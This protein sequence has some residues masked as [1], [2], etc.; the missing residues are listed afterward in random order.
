MPSN[1]NLCVGSF[2]RPR[3]APWPH[4]IYGLQ[5]A[6]SDGV[7]K[8][9]GDRVEGDYAGEVF[10][11]GLLETKARVEEIFP[12]L[13]GSGMVGR[14]WGGTMPFTP[15][16][17][18]PARL[19]VGR[20]RSHPAWQRSRMPSIGFGFNGALW[21]RSPFPCGRGSQCQIL[22]AFSEQAPPFPRL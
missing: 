16:Q 2:L 8:F 4:H 22:S 20:G 19:R 11:E 6:K 13:Q 7:C 3:G 14:G 12:V 10:A 9:G 17:A 15:G 18:G 1:L 5:V 21:N